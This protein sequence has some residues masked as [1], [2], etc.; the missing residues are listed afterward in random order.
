MIVSIHS[1]RDF[2]QWRREAL[3][4]IQPSLAP[5]GLEHL[6][7]CGF[8]LRQAPMPQWLDRGPAG[9]ARMLESR[10]RLKLRRTLI[11]ARVTRRADISLALL[12][13]QSY[14]YSLLATLRVPPWSA[15]PLAALTCWLA[16]DFRVAGPRMRAWLRR[17]VKDTELFIYFS[18][19]QRA[20]LTEGL[21][22]PEERLCF[23][24]FGIESD[25]FT[26]RGAGS[27]ERY[28]LAA[29]IDRGRDYRTFLSAVARLDYPVKLLCPRHQLRGL[30]IPAH[31]ETLG[32][33]ERPRYRE[34]V[35]DA[36]LVVVP[37]LPAVSYPTGQSVLLAAMSC[38]VP[39]VVTQTA[40]LSDYTRHAQNSW[41]VPGEDAE[42]L[43]AGIERVL[44]DPRLAGEIALGGRQDV[45]ARF[46][47]ETMWQTLAPR[48]RALRQARS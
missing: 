41:T 6:E 32:F 33:V 31:V 36:A 37:V 28:V 47:T 12:E 44:G 23:V 20:I 40:A 19:N 39:T 48:L 4:G 18:S 25:Y 24:H 34:L 17:C 3:S 46:N 8:E 1:S 35:R 38:Q 30:E 27:G 42:A 5:Y 9:A 11:S 21:G 16:D 13:P 43:L 26:P 45:E 2:E 14:A 29:G 7:R 22:I 10:T 15:T